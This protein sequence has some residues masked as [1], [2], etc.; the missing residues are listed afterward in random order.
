MA[1][2]IDLMLHLSSQNPAEL[3]RAESM[4]VLLLVF[5]SGS[6]KRSQLAQS[7]LSMR[8]HAASSKDMDQWRACSTSICRCCI[9]Q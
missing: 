7:S 3:A 9:A 6:H 1:G 2:G 5:E 8:D 4:V